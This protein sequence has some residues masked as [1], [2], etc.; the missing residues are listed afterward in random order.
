MKATHSPQLAATRASLRRSGGVAWPVIGCSQWSDQNP[1]SF[2][3]GNGENQSDE[4][5]ERERDRDRTASALA[6]LRLGQDDTRLAGLSFHHEA[7][8][9]TRPNGMPK[10]CTPSARSAMSTANNT[11]R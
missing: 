1:R 10:C 8:A 5:A 6:L 9:N 7:H 4:N 2:D 3:Q 11:N